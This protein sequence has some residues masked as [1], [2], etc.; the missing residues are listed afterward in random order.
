MPITKEFLDNIRNS[1]LTENKNSQRLELPPVPEVWQDDNNPNADLSEE[2]LLEQF[3]LNLKGLSGESFL[4]DNFDNLILQTA[5]TIRENKSAEAKIM[6]SS[7]P[8]ARQVA[9]QLQS[10][11]DGLVGANGEKLSL[12]FCFDSVGGELDLLELSSCDF[13]LVSAEFL[14]ADTG[15][16]VFHAASRFERLAIYLP[17]IS[18]VIAGREKLTKNLPT[19]WQ[20]LGNEIKNQK[21]GE[22]V[23]VT[24]PSRT[25]DIE[26]ILILGVHGPR[27]VLF[28]VY[29]N[30]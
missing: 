8:I 23:I 16:G 6:V 25:A 19:A 15:S 3:Q 10:A 20:K 22:L 9:D 7:N 30:T 28:M 24:G 26:K 4:C 2:K 17:P 21:T 27:R 5:K 12:T 14:L 1:I 18:I 11:V 13:G 29:P